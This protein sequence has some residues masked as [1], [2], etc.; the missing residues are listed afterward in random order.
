MKPFLTIAIVIAAGPW[1]S[2]APLRVL[3][4]GN[5]P[6]LTGQCA[7]ALKAGGAQVTTGEPSETKLATADVVIL[8]SDKFEQLSTSDQ[9]ALS[10][11]AK[12]GGGIVAINGGVAAGP[13]AWG[14]EVLGGA[15]DPADSRKFKELMMLYVVSNSHAIVKDSSPFDIT[16]ETYYDL[17]ISD[18]AYVIAS[19]FTPYGKNPKRGEGP[20]VPDKDVRSNIYDLQPQMWTYEGEDKHRASVILQ[21]APETLAHA[22]VRT[23]I[24]RSVAWAGKLENV[25]TFSVKADLATLRYPAGG[26]L[27]AADAIKKF[28][29]QP[30]FVASV[31]AEEP[32]V[33]KPIAIQ[34]DGRGRMWVA[35]T[36]E[37]PNGKRPLNAPAWKETG[38]REPGN[39]DRP[40]RDSISILEDT[41]GDGEMDKKNIFHTGL[42]LVTGFTLSGKGVIA[43]AQPHIVYLED[44][45]GDG[46]ADKETPL[47]EGFAPGDTHFVANHFVEAPDGWV[48]VSTGSGADAKSV[49]TGKVT[50]ISPGVFRFRTDGSV[51]EQVASQGGNSFGGEVTSDMEIYHG[52]ATSGNP[53]E[54][55]V[56]PEWV[57][58]KSSTK[59]GAFSS[60]NPGRQVARKDL[61]E[62]A[63]IRQIDQVGRFTAAC[64]T[65]VYEGGAWPKEYNGMIFTTEPILDIIHCETIKQDGP[66][67]KGPEK[68]DIQAEWLRST[69]YWFCPVDV[70]FGPDGAMYVLD[71]NTPVVTHN[72][73]RGPEHSKSNASIRPDRD[74]YFGRIF[75]IQ[76]KDAPKFP[77]PD[78]DSA[79]AAALVAAF[80][81]P[82]KVVRFNAIRI[83]LEKGDT[84]GKQ[85]VPALTT[86]AAGE[87]VASSRILA[88]WALNRLGQLKDTTL[89]SAMG[90][91]DSHIRKNAYL[92]AESAGIPISGS[93]AKAGIDDDDARVRLAT[94][95]ALG[96]STM[97]PEASA[98]LLASNSKFG[99]D[100][101]K[102]AAAAAGAK[103]PTS[104]L[105]SV[106][107]DATGAGQ[108][109][110]SI[111][112][113]AAALVS[114][115]NTAQIPGVVKAA[116]AS[117][118]A[119]FVIAVLQEFGKS[120]N[121]PR[122][123][124]G[125]INALRVLLTSSNKR[126]AISAL[127]VA[128]VWDKSGTLAKESTK[129][130]GELLNA[131]RDPNVPETTRAEA[132]RT[133][134][135]ARS[136][137]KFI[138]PNVAALLAK[139]QPESLTKDL[140]TSLAATGEPEAG[141]A[142]I[143]AYPTLKDDQKEI[144]FNALAGRPEWAKQL[145][146]AIESKKIAAES[147]TPAL[148]SRLTAHPDA[149]VSASAKALFGGGTSSGKDE[150]VSKLLPDIEKPGN[151]ENGKT[152]F[153]AMCAV[154]HKIE[155]AGN[156][157]GP[158]LDGIGAHP[159]RELLTHIV[160]PSLVV[161]DEH[162]T[163][164]ITMK[165]GTLHSALIASENEARVQIRMPGGVTQDLKT[166]EIA[167]RV[168]GANSLMPE[169]LEAIGTD[170][171]RDIIG[172]IRSVAPKSE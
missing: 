113:M 97:T 170:N 90:S 37:Y 47:F 124:A 111:R 143:D 148:V 21:G 106:L 22:S 84:L 36:P 155:G 79:N 172:Y 110:E 103:A 158:N 69:D 29:M 76:H 58:A 93:Q 91:P 105:E 4:T 146:A 78:L 44:T 7:T 167:S 85:A 45:D 123:A 32:L 66:V 151:I 24:L 128:A 163:W 17:D 137:N 168:K 80:K 112:T 171:L 6:A 102:A 16:D 117:K 12:R 64:S 160:N 109:E 43:V 70:S 5:N 28:Q 74:Q 141:K 18:K 121:A 142:I 48:Y 38:V 30:G 42:E 145:L 15:W 73:T 86:M 153:T 77:I 59:A 60:V 1:L 8:Q 125:A 88:L 119:P 61:P 126:V 156:V 41:N 75:R 161:D 55:V 67:M 159:V 116:A 40:G 9:T 34:W 157:F 39:Y 53:I 149:A 46:K 83:L 118:N 131:A 33:N 152:L 120:Q 11:F 154:C 100:W 169:G 23:F 57:L 19:A 35:E 81:H 104:Q 147:F 3:I 133:L 139:P 10:A 62:R 96:A 136:L 65:A 56:M 144:A 82:N 150:L 89:A 166:S 135:P 72:D 14:K 140:L 71:F 25:D 165:D 129:V 99:D 20:R 31:V 68:M 115:E 164:N 132:V 52:K 107:A 162:R 13:S 87:P 122:G 92:I 130:A 114:G 138:L 134:L 51:I 27:R 101:S 94:L 108:T 2:A 54:H 26:P 98:V 49:K 63:N 50:K 95:R 127:P